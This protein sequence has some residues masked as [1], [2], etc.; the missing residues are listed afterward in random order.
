MLNEM[1]RNDFDTEMSEIKK[2]MD[3]NGEMIKDLLINKC[4]LFKDEWGVF[5]NDN[6]NIS[7]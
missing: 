2:Q 7:S 3:A 4:T 5:S 6:D 1:N